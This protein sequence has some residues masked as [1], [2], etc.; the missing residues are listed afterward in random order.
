[1]SKIRGRVVQRGARRFLVTYHPAAGM[2]FPAARAAM[3]Q[4]FRKL[5]RLSA[6]MDLTL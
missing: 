2:R 6:G 1:M 4:D 5:R 3:E